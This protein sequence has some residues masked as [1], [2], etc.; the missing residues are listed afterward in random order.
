MK[1]KVWKASEEETHGP[2]GI[3]KSPIVEA[4]GRFAKLES[5]TPSAICCRSRA[6]CLGD[7]ELD[8]LWTRL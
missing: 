5:A 7:L 6:P 4:Y 8:V 2:I 3:S 1:T